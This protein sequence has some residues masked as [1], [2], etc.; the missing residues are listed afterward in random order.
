MPKIKSIES[1]LHDWV[2]ALPFQ[3]QA[4]LMTA[5]RG[6]DGCNK[7]NAAKAI[8]RFLRGAI[9]KPA[10]N[11][12]G[13]NNNDFMWGDYSVFDI[14]R[15]NFFGDPDGYPHHFIMH[16]THCAEVIGYKHPDDERA[17]YWNMFYQTAC[18]S[19]HMWAESVDEMDARLNDFG[20]PVSEERPKEDVAFPHDIISFYD[21]ILKR[22]IECPNEKAYSEWCYWMFR[23]GRPVHRIRLENDIDEVTYTIGQVVENGTIIELFWRGN[24]W[25]YKNEKGDIT[26]IDGPIKGDTYHRDHPGFVQKGDRESVLS[27]GVKEEK[28]Q[29]LPPCGCT[30]GED[31]NGDCI[32]PAWVA[33]RLL[34][35]KDALVR[36]DR[37]EAYHWLYSIACPDFSSY[38]PWIGLED[39]A[40]AKLNTIPEARKPIAIPDAGMSQGEGEVSFDLREWAQPFVEKLPTILEGNA[41][42]YGAKE[43][44]QK[45]QEE[46][47]QA[48]EGQIFAVLRF[49]EQIE[50]LR[51][52]NAAL[53][54][55]NKEYGEKYAEAC[56][57]RDGAAAQLEEARKALDLINE[58]SLTLANA[59]K[60]AFEFL[61]KYPSLKTD[62]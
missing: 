36:D 3:Q 13:L 56:R 24:Y 41:F 38:H 58:K 8:V 50:A 10:G 31:C 32:I 9:C 11:W 17:K 12:D 26:W 40:N 59:E 39:F 49:A 61:Y 43:I 30:S 22:P 1:A 23:N 27:E 57:Q 51:F 19:L 54:A 53:L 15:D 6:P 55:S 33:Q 45:M 42:I 34:K 4:L 48:K 29:V 62:K 25:G 7:H 21:E 18:R 44:Y 16:L 52:T 35:I 46:V 20:I 60:I 2:H 47:D 28:K 5:M 37:D 14:W